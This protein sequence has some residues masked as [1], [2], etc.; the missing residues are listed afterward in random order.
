MKFKTRAGGDCRDPFL[1]LTCAW[2]GIDGRVDFHARP[3]RGVV[4]EPVFRGFHTGRVETTASKE[5]S[6]AP[7]AGAL[8][9]LLLGRS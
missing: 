3:V 4:H 2:Y 7:A 6:V 1:G 9:N 5:R 8:E